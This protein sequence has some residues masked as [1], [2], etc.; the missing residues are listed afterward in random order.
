M[1]AIRFRKILSYLAPDLSD[2]FRAA[3]PL[4]ARIALGVLTGAVGAM[5]LFAPLPGAE[6]VRTN[7]GLSAGARSPSFREAANAAVQRKEL[8]EERSHEREEHD[9]PPFQPLWSR[10]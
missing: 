1:R 3:V 9:T 6:F 8:V 5:L 7:W 4:P 2:E 10:S